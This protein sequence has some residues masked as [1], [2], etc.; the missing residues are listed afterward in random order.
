MKWIDL[1]L[2]LNEKFVCLIQIVCCYF[3]QTLLSVSSNYESQTGGYPS[4]QVQKLR[5]FRDIKNYWSI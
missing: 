1:K 3:F 2:N 4:T 5:K